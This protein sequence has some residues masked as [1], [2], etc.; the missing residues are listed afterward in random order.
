LFVADFKPF[1]VTEASLVHE[2]VILAWKKQRLE[3]VEHQYIMHKLTQPVQCFELPTLTVPK[4]EGAEKYI[5]NP[6]LIDDSDM[7]GLCASIRALSDLLDSDGV[8]TDF[9][10]I[11][12]S[13][14]SVFE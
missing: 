10:E 2:L 1:G 5:V 11:Q 9:S 8:V 4:V 12:S 13:A 6:D 3:G 14:P 7:A